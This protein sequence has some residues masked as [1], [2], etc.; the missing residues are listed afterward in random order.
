LSYFH[1]PRAKGVPVAQH[2]KILVAGHERILDGV[3][4]IVMVAED[5]YGNRP[6]GTLVTTYKLREGLF[7]AV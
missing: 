5:I 2:T 7:F 3:L 1:Q 6:D 4:N